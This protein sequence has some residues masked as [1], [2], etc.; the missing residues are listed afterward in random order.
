VGVDGVNAHV[1]VDG[2]NAHVLV[3]GVNAHVLAKFMALGCGL[4]VP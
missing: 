1:L 2:V 4:A 3:D